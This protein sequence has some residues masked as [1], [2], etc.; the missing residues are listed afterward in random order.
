M[1]TQRKSP[2]S[3]RY[4]LELCGK[5]DAKATLVM[6]TWCEQNGVCSKRTIHSWTRASGSHIRSLEVQS[7]EGSEKSQH[8]VTS[9]TFIR[10]LVLNK[11]LWRAKVFLR[12]SCFK[13]FIFAFTSLHFTSLHSTSL[14]FTALHFTSL[15][16]TS[17]HFTHF[18]L[19]DFTSHHFTALSLLYW[20]HFT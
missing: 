9:I 12:T 16:F 8:G 7:A 20:F 18:F 1:R 15:H 17:L 11:I 19:L 3:D 6:L 4:C 10:R 5:E 13:V 14:L 2:C